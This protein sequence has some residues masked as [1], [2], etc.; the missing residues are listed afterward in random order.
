MTSSR[1]EYSLLLPIDHANHRISP[2]RLR[3]LRCWAVAG[4]H[5]RSRLVRHAPDHVAQVDAGDALDRL[6]DHGHHA[7]HVVSEVAAGLAVRRD[8][9]HLF[10]LRQRRRDALCDGRELLDNLPNQPNAS[11]NQPNA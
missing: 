5:I 6:G 9:D 8:E 1:D 10:G 2:L 7:C 4:R 3:S 11:A